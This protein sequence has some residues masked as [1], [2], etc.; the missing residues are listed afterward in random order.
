MSRVTAIAAATV[1]AVSLSPRA[2]SLG[3]GRSGL[4]MLPAVWHRVGYRYNHEPP[5]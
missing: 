1:F 2:E 5:T 4:H 3:T